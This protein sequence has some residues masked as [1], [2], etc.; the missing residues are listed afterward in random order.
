MIELNP[1]GQVDQ[2]AGDLIKDVSEATFMADVVEASRTVPI[3]VDFWAPWC[4]PCKMMAPQFEQAAKE[5]EPG[6]RFAKLNTDEAQ[7][8]AAR[9]NIRSIPTIALFRNGREVARQPGAMSAADI[10]RWVQAH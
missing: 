5:L 8:T 7:G 6:I 2:P 3:I 4:G 1:N 10:V 9:F